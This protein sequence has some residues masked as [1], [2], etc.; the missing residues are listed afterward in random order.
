MDEQCI[1]ARISGRVQGVG[2]RASTRDQ[3]LTRGISGYV[4]NL[5]DGRVEVMA[6]GDDAAL[7]WLLEWLH[8]GPA[9]ASVE[10]VD[11]ETVTFSPGKDFSIR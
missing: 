11:V 7:E 10:H 2:F 1:K 9:A 3:A 4:R 8:K 6:C 5:S